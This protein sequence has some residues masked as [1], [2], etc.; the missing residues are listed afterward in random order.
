MVARKWRGIG[1]YDHFL[2]L[3]EGEMRDL[4]RYYDVDWSFFTKGPAKSM[5]GQYFCFVNLSRKVF[6]L[7]PFLSLAFG[8]MYNTLPMENAPTRVVIDYDSRIRR[9]PRPSGENEIFIAA[10]E[11]SMEDFRF[12]K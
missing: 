7:L 5:D 8:G 9:G 10:A 3:D 2:T 6:A 4:C 11:F 1:D 12:P